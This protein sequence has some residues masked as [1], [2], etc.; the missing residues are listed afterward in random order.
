MRKELDTELDT[1]ICNTCGDYY[2][3]DDE[4][5]GECDVCRD[6]IFGT[7]GQLGMGA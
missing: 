4:D 2:L 3:S 6:D 5:T 1:V 7:N